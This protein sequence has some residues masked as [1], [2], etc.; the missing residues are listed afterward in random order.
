V[1]GRCRPRCPSGR[2]RCG[3]RCCPKGHRCQNPRRGVCDRCPRGKQPCGKRCC[4]K[5]SFCCGDANG[6]TCCPRKG[7]SC[8]SNRD[9]RGRAQHICCRRPTRC[10]RPVAVD[11]S[12]TAAG[13]DTAGRYSCCPEERY[14]ERHRACCPPG[15]VSLGGAFVLPPGGGG[16]LC[17]RKDKLCGSGDSRT[18]CGRGSAAFP[19]LEQT[20]CGG[21]CVSTAIDPGNCGGCGIV[22]P[23]G[24]RCQG[25]ACIPA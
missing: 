12:G 3:D 23:S 22:C 20:C 21:R 24:Q 8:C 13:V 15:H 5:S 25:G 10:A 9:A 2:V 14:V 7:G 6:G 17:C 16:G 4:P 11:A 18:C 19:E 1:G